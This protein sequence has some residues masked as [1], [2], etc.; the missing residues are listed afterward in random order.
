MNKLQPRS[1]LPLFHNGPGDPDSSAGGSPL[2]AARADAFRPRTLQQ[3]VIF[4]AVAAFLLFMASFVCLFGLSLLAALASFI[5]M[6]YFRLTA[7]Y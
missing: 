7:T 1:A 4:L 5:E 2:S 3:W 6:L